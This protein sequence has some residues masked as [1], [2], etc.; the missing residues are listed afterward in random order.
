MSHE[1]HSISNDWLLD[2][3][4]QQQ[5]NINKNMNPFHYGSL[6]RGMYWWQVDSLHNGSVVQKGVLMAWPYNVQNFFLFVLE[7]EKIHFN[8]LL[9]DKFN[10]NGWQARKAYWGNH[11]TLTVFKAIVNN[12]STFC[13]LDWKYLNKFHSKG[14]YCPN[15]WL[16]YI[17]FIQVMTWHCKGDMLLL[18]QWPVFM[19]FISM[20]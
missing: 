2:C 14:V 12:F 4:F 8:C 1:R 18:I 20:G 17:G 10:V 15:G 19:L 13:Y 9:C 3:F 6:E 5:G 16:V 7:N 11:D